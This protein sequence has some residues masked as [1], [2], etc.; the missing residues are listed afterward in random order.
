MANISHSNLF[1][2]VV[3]LIISVLVTYLYIDYSYLWVK[4]GTGYQR[5]NPLIYFIEFPLVIVL[6]SIFFFPKIKNWSVRYLLPIIPVIILYFLFD[7]F[8]TFLGRSPFPSDFENITVIFNF[9]TLLAVGVILLILLIPIAIGVLV[10][11]SAKTYAS[12]NL[13]FTLFVRAGGIAVLF[14]VF[15]SETFNQL[16]QSQFRYTVWSPEDTIR[17]NGK[18]SSFLY[19]SNQEYQNRKKL[20]RWSESFINAA[21]KQN[22]EELWQSP[23]DTRLDIY[24][25][26]YSGEVLKPRNVHVIVLESFIDPRLIEELQLPPSVLASQLLP[27][28]NRNKDFS[29]V[30]SPIYGGGTAQAEFELLT[31]IKALSKV[32]QIE[33][34][35][36]QGGAVSSFIRRLQ[37]HD[38]RTIATIGPS[39]SFF[40]SKQAYQSLGFYEIQYL[41]DEL[42]LADFLD[43]APLFDGDLLEQNL[44]KVKKHFE[45][46]KQPLFNYVLGMYG[47]LPFARDE[48]KRPDVVT[49]DHRDDRLRRISNQFYYRTKAIA[50][51]LER[52]IE[53]DKEAII[54][55]TSDH[56]PSILGV[57]T[58]Y[59]LDNKVNI[60]LLISHGK[61]IDV[62][63]KR[64]FE[65]PWVIWD[66][67]VG[68][69]IDRNLSDDAM[70]NLYFQ[71]LSE[72]L[73]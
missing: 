69:K 23:D 24:Q 6:S 33:F 58:N 48:D 1:R 26:L 40:N 38:Y 9:S 3:F 42:E 45:D 15:N 52:L 59:Q 28:L 12:K 39:S 66:L 61:T 31:G 13:R 18:F 34:N 64:L 4:L 44:I 65:I 19:Y 35:V 47:H 36:M 50:H 27:Y 57:R 62:S 17:E 63:G 30:I 41:Q 68:E 49:V 16:H 55:I 53:L 72:S 67:L 37:Q 22:K 46:N 14:F 71:L 32:N 51:Y 43:E 10:Y 8:Y 7:S 73:Q 56:L 11:F 54:Y 2:T 29:H 21:N 60:A 70:L 5:F 25:N 20:T